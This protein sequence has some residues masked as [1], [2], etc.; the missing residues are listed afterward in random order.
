MNAYDVNATREREQRSYISGLAT[1]QR[2]TSRYS[3]REGAPLQE[4]GWAGGNEGCWATARPAAPP[5]PLPR[6]FS[7]NPPATPSFLPSPPCP[8]ARTLTPSSP[9]SRP[10][11]WGAIRRFTPA[12][13]ST[14]AV[15]RSYSSSSLFL[16]FLR[17]L[18]PFNREFSC[19][20]MLY[21]VLLSHSLF[22][23]SFTCTSRALRVSSSRIFHL[24]P[25]IRHQ[26]SGDFYARL[27]IFKG[28]NTL[29]TS[30]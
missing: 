8:L 10:G 18:F 25:L 28:V 9:L 15:R 27:D 11:P 24:A 6:A 13:P 26:A 5:S 2:M 21:R 19:P 22:L 29:V 4:K 1:G 23:V 12:I 16:Y 7:Q 17:S 14:D 30:D 20:P 3:Q